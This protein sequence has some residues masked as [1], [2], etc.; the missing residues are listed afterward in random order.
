[1]VALRACAMWRSRGGLTTKLH[2]VTDACRLPV[3]L[4]LTVGQAH[5]GK[6]GLALIGTLGS[7]LS[8]LA[9]A[10][11]DMNALRDV[12]AARRAEAQIMPL[13]RRQH[14]HR[15]SRRELH[16]S[17]A[18]NDAGND[19]LSTVN[20]QAGVLMRVVHTS[21]S[22]AGVWRLQPKPV[23]GERHLLRLHT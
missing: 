2:A 5:D 11:Y 7:G 14:R 16:R 3:A 23:S 4:H 19:Q 21:G 22:L 1:M 17:V 8:L 6:T 18:R 9:D 10:A 15:E 12:L 13:A 20:G